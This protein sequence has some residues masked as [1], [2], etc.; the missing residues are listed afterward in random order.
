MMKTVEGG[1][2]GE[3]VASGRAKMSAAARERVEALGIAVD[4]KLAPKYDAEKWAECVKVMAADLF[5]GVEDGEAQRRLA[6]LR[7]DEFARSWKG[8]LVFALARLS[9][10]ARAVERF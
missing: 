4:G 8:K 3:L 10:K 6:H 5:P 1:S 7:M 9:P 2:V